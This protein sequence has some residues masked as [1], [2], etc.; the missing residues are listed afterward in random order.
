MKNKKILQ[1]VYGGLF[2]A[3]V[4][5]AT[6]FF[7]IPTAIG[8]VNLGDGVL[9]SAATMLGPY[10]AIP[11]AL[12]SALADLLLGYTAYAPITFVVKGVMGLLA[13]FL[14]VKRDRLFNAGNLFAFLL[15]EVWM[16]A[17]YFA[18]ETFAYGLAAA[19]GSIIPNLLQGVAGI[20]LALILTPILQK[21]RKN[22]E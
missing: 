2:T 14:L 5:I 17:G 18:F 11:A 21:V 9:L 13:G 6:M 12:G 8:Y 20:V 16:A 1:L 15:C 7:K 22:H 19:T 4:T 10:A 3:L